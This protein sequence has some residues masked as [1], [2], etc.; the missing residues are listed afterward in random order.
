MGLIISRF[1]RK[2]TTIEILDRLETDI[3]GIE[4]DGQYKEQTHKRVIGYIMAYSVGLYVLFAIL[5]Y[6]MYVGRSQHWMYSLLYASPLLVLP[7]LV[8]FLRSGISWYYNWTINKNRLKLSK[9]RAEKKKILEEV[10]NTETYKVA[11]EILDKY[12]TPEDQSKALKPFVPS[13]NVPGNASSTT[14]PATPGQLRQRQQM[15]MQTSTPINNN[16]MLVPIGNTPNPGF[17]GARLRSEQLPRPLPERNRSALDRVVDFLLK[18]GPHNRMA[19]ICSECSAHNGMAMT[20]EFDYVSYVCAYCGRFNPARKQKPAAPLLAA[21]PFP[22]LTNN[23]MPGSGDDSS[24]P[25]SASE[26]DD[27][28]PAGDAC[29]K[30]GSEGDSDRPPS[31]EGTPKSNQDK[32]ED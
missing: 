7:I 2:K 8:I 23:A 21:R 29:R 18:D 31:A 26:S 13:T 9:M 32:K 3:K 4:R 11:K 10:M 28:K 12:G 24:L 6:Y 17:R 5:Y 14:P 20:E 30:H 1:R 15:A 25:S 16:R 19:L 27:D 22:A